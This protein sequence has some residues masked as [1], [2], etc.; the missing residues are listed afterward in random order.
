MSGY[1]GGLHRLVL[2]F[3]L[4]AVPLVQAADDFPQRP[5]TLVV[6]YSAGGPSD[7]LAR[8][9]ARS[10]SHTLGVPVDVENVPGKGGTIGSLQVAKSPAD[11]YRL[12]FH[13]IGHATV[14]FVYRWQPYNV[15]R[16]FAPIG[17]VADLP[18]TVVA[19]K[20]LPPRTLLELIEYI[21]TQ[22]VPVRYADAGVGSASHLCYIL[23]AE[24]AGVSLASSSY[25]GTSLAMA[26][27]VSGNVDLMCDQTAN[28]LR[29]IRSGAIKVY[30]QTGRVRSAVL[31][32]VPTAHEAGLANFEIVVWNG[33]YAPAGTPPSVIDTLADALRDAVADAN[34]SR[35]FAELGATPVAQSQATPE[36]L[37]AQLL[38]E[39]EKWSRFIRRPSA[40]PE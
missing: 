7:M 8:G 16:D 37:R 38:S 31:P 14:P 21:K 20:D 9:L 3:C 35:Q 1:S 22:K 34:L 13:H 36:A 17:L 11:G 32:E 28:T 5:I 33:I 30:A 23:L 12:L 4:C 19:R 39:L 6:P 29:H 2:L 18:M 27:L 15:V 10:M 40:Y 24:A 26:D 25:D